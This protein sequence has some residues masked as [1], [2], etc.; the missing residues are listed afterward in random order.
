MPLEHQNYMRR[1]FDL[2][3][4]GRPHVRL[5]PLVGSVI[6]Y[7]H[8]I[9]GEGYHKKYGGPHA[10]IEALN[11][12]RIE[13]L[14]YLTQSTLYVN[15]AP[16]NHVG[17]T[18]PCSQAIIDAGIPEVVIAMDEKNHLAQGGVD[19][20]RKAGVQVTLD[21]LSREAN[22]LNRPFLKGLEQLHPYVTLKW[23]ES[24]DG[25]I[26]REGGQV[27]LSNEQTKLKVHDMRSQNNAILVGSNT[28]ASDN[29]QLTTREVPGDHPIRVILVG[30]EALPGT[31][32]I[33]IDEHP[34]LIF[35]P[36]DHSYTLK[37]GKQVIHYEGNKID[38]SNLLSTLFS[39]YNI[40]YLMV[41]GGAKILQQFIDED[42]WD[43]IYQIRT[44]LRL[45]F[46]I[47]AP[48][49]NLLPD[50]KSTIGTDVINIFKA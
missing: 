15:L 33:M 16:C 7:Q 13:D 42:L 27:S 20:L 6:V 45:S 1:C 17:K 36:N 19:R 5:N 18:P 22:D 49:L 43:E 29:P 2:A 32:Q 34:L 8:R 21:I 37:E 12:V 31:A 40:G 9:I 4:K 38:I 25:F 39:V 30:S 23:A 24:H 26:G 14:P 46:G 50:K 28:I 35:A 44:P 11:S 47:S 10:E 3:K 41:E 48:K